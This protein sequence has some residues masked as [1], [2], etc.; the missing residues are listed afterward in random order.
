[1]KNIVDGKIYDSDT[2][3]LVADSSM[4]HE[5]KLYRTWKLYHSEEGNWFVYMF[6]GKDNFLECRPFSDE[7]ACSWLL[8]NNEMEAVLKYFPGSME[9]V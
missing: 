1:M 4:F 6:E 7:E 5:G 3:H 2:A 9:E 8:E